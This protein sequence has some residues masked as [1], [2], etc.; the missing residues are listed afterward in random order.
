MWWRRSPGASFSTCLHEGR[1]LGGAGAGTV[2]VLPVRTVRADLTPGPALR[3][4]PVD[5]KALADLRGSQSQ[6]DRGARGLPG[7]QQPASLGEPEER[8]LRIPAEPKLLGRAGR[9]VGPGCWRPVRTLPHLPSCRCCCAC[10]RGLLAE[11]STVLP[12]PFN[13]GDLCPAALCLVSPGP[14]SSGCFCGLPQEWLSSAGQR[15]TPCTG[16][17]WLGSAPRSRRP[18]R[19]VAGPEAAVQSA[20]GSHLALW[21]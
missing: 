21:L 18:G 12:L 14:E 16:H 15:A 11:A 1:V 4:V 19:A 3:P 8:A 10:L 20:P 2:P 7:P 5:R 9:C 13:T 17:H 6:E